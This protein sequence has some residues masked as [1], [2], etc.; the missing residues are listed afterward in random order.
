MLTTG[1]RIVNLFTSLLALRVIVEP[2]DPGG[3]PPPP[4]QGSRWSLCCPWQ[5]ATREAS[6]WAGGGGGGQSHAVGVPCVYAPIA[7]VSVDTHTHTHTHTR[8]V[9]RS[10]RRRTCPGPSIAGL[11]NL[12]FHFHC[13]IN[14]DSCLDRCFRPNS[15]TKEAPSPPATL[16]LSLSLSLSSGPI[17]SRKPLNHFTFE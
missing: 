8:V 16:S 9:S 1:S 2:C 11:L 3:C 10:H 7:N 4:A 17:D 12:S 15:R 13:P 14:R 5:A 6:C